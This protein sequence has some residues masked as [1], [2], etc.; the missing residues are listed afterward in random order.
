[1][2][3]VTIRCQGMLFF[4]V[5]AYV[6]TYLKLFTE[7]FT[8]HGTCLC[9]S[10]SS[11][12]RLICIKDINLKDILQNIP[13]NSSHIMLTAPHVVRIKR[14]DFKGFSNLKSFSIKATSLKTIEEHS[15]SH[16]VNL[17][18][19]SLENTLMTNIEKNLL[20]GLIKLRVFQMTNCKLLKGLHQDLFNETV[21]LE[22]IF[23]TEGKLATLHN[24]TFHN[25]PNL[26]SIYF[27]KNKLTQLRYICLIIQSHDT[28]TER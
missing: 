18:R 16:L 8:C 1:M 22:R 28:D 13:L 20:S 7:A 15:F 21:L 24:S 12:Y 26:K 25:L 6:I 11:V 27:H 9:D 17:D 2:C 10:R 23:I 4:L 3:Q 5:V 19:L 14:N